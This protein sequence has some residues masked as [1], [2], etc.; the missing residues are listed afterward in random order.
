MATKY[1]W[2]GQYRPNL[3]TQDNDRDQLLDVKSA[4][5]VKDEDIADDII[6]SGSEV[7]RET[8]LDL[9]ARR[10]KALAKRVLQGFTYAN[11]LV[12]MQPRV[13]GVFK[14]INTPF[15]PAVNKCVIDITAAS[16]LRA[17]LAEVSVQIMGSKDSGGAKIGTVRNSLT[18]AEDGTIPIGDDVVIEGE[19]IKVSDETDEAQGVFFIDSTG[20]EHRVTRKFTEN[21][22]SKIIARVPASVPAIRPHASIGASARAWARIRS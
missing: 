8:M 15:D 14:D 10:E 21:K 16:P 22:P 3:F 5:Q 4:G 12:Q 18:G 9:F 11:S 19:K 7:S 6:A 13:T 2:T 20:K 1:S 17:E